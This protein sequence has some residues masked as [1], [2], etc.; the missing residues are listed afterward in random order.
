MVGGLTDCVTYAG[1]GYAFPSDA[2]SAEALEMLVEAADSPASG[3]FCSA[4]VLE[5]YVSH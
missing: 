4:A 2:D 3:A 1:A 5:I